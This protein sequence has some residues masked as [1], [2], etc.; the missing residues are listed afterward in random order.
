MQN[1]LPNKF[2]KCSIFNE[3][4]PN[5]ETALVLTARGLLT[6]VVWCSQ[7]NSSIMQCGY[8]VRCAMCSVNNCAVQC[9]MRYAVLSVVCNVQC[10]GVCCAVSSIEC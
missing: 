7:V 9:C 5:F 10:Y 8:A 6:L 1:K 4:S 3:K 2:R